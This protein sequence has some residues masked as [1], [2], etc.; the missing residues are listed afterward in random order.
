MSSIFFSNKCAGRFFIGLSVI[1]ASFGCATSANKFYALN[2]DLVDIAQLPGSYCENIISNGWV[3]YA[4]F[5]NWDTKDVCLL[6]SQEVKK[7]GLLARQN[8]ITGVVQ[9]LDLTKINPKLNSFVGIDSDDS[10]NVYMVTRDE[11]ILVKVV[12]NENIFH[13]SEIE[14]IK[15][16]LPE[17]GFSTNVLFY[18]EYVYVS[19]M[20]HGLFLRV[21]ANDF[22]SE[23]VDIIDVSSI[24]SEATGYNGLC[25]DSNGFI[26]A[27]PSWNGKTR[28]GKVVRINSSDFTIN[29]TTIIDLSLI[30]PKAKGYH[31]V[32][33]CDGKVIFSPH[34][35]DDEK[36]H[37][38]IA[39]IDIDKPTINGVVILDAN[40][41]NSSIGGM[42]NCERVGESVWFFPYMNNKDDQNREDPDTIVILDTK[43]LKQTY[44]NIAGTIKDAA[45]IFYDGAFDGRYMFLSPHKSFIDGKKCWDSRALKIDT[46]K[47]VK[48]ME[49]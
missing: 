6:S 18:K 16:S 3:Y 34:Y 26:W 19:P 1:V 35:S 36:F 40:T 44:L 37:G 7:S 30:N 33:Y 15:L 23:S 28:I 49:K 11:S 47:M 25:V 43:T 20:K 21:K 5:I 17:E 4:P 27:A 2:K 13:L 9:V 22:S 24:D 48:K 14:T 29:G 38:N 41:E 31:G 12:V 42:V 45:A 10:G 8:I 39:I 46:T 32:C